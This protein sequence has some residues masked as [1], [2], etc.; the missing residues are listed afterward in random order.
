MEEEGT[1]ININ[2]L[3]FLIQII[4]SVLT[5]S[6]YLKPVLLTLVTQTHSY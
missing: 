2:K 4:I 3:T 1:L 5:P 6:K